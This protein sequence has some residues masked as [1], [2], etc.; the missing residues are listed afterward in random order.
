VPLH[1]HHVERLVATLGR[2]GSTDADAVAEEVSALAL[3]GVRIDLVLSAPE[4]ASLV[5]AL[6]RIQAESQMPDPAYGRLLALAREQ[7]SA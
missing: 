2:L 7:Q 4:L 6:L 1:G 5:T 3:A